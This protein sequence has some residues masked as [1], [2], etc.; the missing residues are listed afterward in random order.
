M[1]CTVLFGE[2]GGIFTGVDSRS[3]FDEYSEVIV[4]RDG[5]GCVGSRREV[6]NSAA[7]GCT[8][9]DCV[10]YKILG[11]AEPVASGTIGLYVVDHPVVFFERIHNYFPLFQL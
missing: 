7:C 5:T 3:R 1:A 2:I 9:V 4:E 10:L 8:C 6:H 11:I